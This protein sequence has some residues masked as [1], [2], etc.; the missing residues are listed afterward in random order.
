[1]ELHQHNT[2]TLPWEQ[3]ILAP[4]GDIQH[5]SQSSSLDSLKRHI[6]MTEELGCYYTGLGDYLDV[7]SPSGRSKYNRA[8]FYDSIKDALD[9]EVYRQLDEVKR[10]LKPT[11]GKWLM[12]NMGH[13]HWTFCDGTNTDQL[14]AEYLGCPVTDDMGI[15]ITNIRFQDK[16]NKRAVTCEVWQWHGLGSSTTMAGP[17]NKL[18]R[19]MVSWPSVDI[20]LMGHYSRAVGWPRDPLVPIFGEKPSLIEK[21]RILACTGSFDKGYTVGGRA[22]YVE[23]GGMPPLN[24]GGVLVYV[25][26]VHRADGERLE[27][28]VYS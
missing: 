24:R 18:E 17:V 2:L 25:K 21:R 4:I 10:V 1:M 11:I 15:G 26:P 28:H 22:T 14:L 7:A 20:F 5:G 3:I 23:K 19:E 8:E 12:L 16:R 9:K 13:H 27:M 6:K